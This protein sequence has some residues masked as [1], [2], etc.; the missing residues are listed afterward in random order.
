MNGIMQQRVYAQNIDKEY[1]KR[2]TK[3]MGHYLSGQDIF[4]KQVSEKVKK[5]QTT[6]CIFYEEEDDAEH[7]IFECD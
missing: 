5:K 3:K 2:G 1:K 6:I 7:R 4:M